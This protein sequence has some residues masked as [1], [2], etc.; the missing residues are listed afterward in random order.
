MLGSADLED[1]GKALPSPSMIVE[2]NRG[3]VPD[4]KSSD[5]PLKIG[6]LELA[7]DERF[8]ST[9]PRRSIKGDE[10]SLQRE[11]NNGGG[12]KGFVD[13]RTRNYNRVRNYNNR[14]EDS[15]CNWKARKR[16]NDGAYTRHIRRVTV[17]ARR[18][19]GGI[20]ARMIKRLN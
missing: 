16:R 9:N 3:N 2:I 1:G 6:R 17:D 18:T 7:V 13:A 4:R 10:A 5:V 12:R 20:I 11:I 8:H 14:V 15:R 19:S